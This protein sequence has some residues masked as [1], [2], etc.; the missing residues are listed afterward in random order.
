[1]ARTQDPTLLMLTS[2]FAQVLTQ[3]AGRLKS[4]NSH[5]THIRPTSRHQ[6][7]SPQ[8]Y[9][10]RP[11]KVTAEVNQFQHTTP[12]RSQVHHRQT[13]HGPRRVTV[14]DRTLYAGRRVRTAARDCCGPCR[15][16]HFDRIR[17]QAADLDGIARESEVRSRGNP[18]GTHSDLP[19]SISSDRSSAILPVANHHLPDRKQSDPRRRYDGC[20]RN[21]RL[22]LR[23]GHFEFQRAPNRLHLGCSATGVRPFR[24]ARR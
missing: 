23:R 10:F 22:G 8:D 21:S 1:M 7:L 15:N 19:S 13:R 20:P 9:F 2:A 11:Q 6:W 18:P 17:L 4:K 3:I 14:H 24:Q 5:S 16:V 12:K